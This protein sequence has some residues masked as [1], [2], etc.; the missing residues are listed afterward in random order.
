MAYYHC[1]IML[2]I[3]N[4]AFMQCS[5]IFIALQWLKIAKPKQFGVKKAMNSIALLI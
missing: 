4:R 2:G 5:K 1:I 3:N